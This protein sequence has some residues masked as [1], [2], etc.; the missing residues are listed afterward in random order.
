MLALL[1]C[2]A[3]RAG[4]ERRPPRALRPPPTAA[5]SIGGRAAVSVDAL[6]AKLAAQ[7][8]WTREK[9]TRR[10]IAIG[11][12][13]ADH[14]NLVRSAMNRR[15]RHGDPEVSQRAL[16]VLKA[17]CPPPKLPP[18]TDALTRAT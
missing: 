17:L 5:V 4:Q 7:G 11:K 1:C 6:T 14:R 2:A 10:L 8:Y 12:K 18:R 15:R 9:A 16:R 3:T 13:D